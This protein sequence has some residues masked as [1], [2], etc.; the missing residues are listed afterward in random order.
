MLNYYL[1]YYYNKFQN[2]SISDNF[3][4][5]NLIVESISTKM[6]IIDVLDSSIRL[7]DFH[8]DIGMLKNIKK[9]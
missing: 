5:L 3:N 7:I 4:E 9:L 6:K 1:D 2:M 8:C